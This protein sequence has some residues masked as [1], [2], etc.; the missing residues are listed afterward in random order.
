MTLQRLHWTGIRL[1]VSYTACRTS[2]SSRSIFDFPTRSD[3]KVVAFLTLGEFA[4][5]VGNLVVD[6]AWQ[7]C[8]VEPDIG[9]E[10]RPFCC[11]HFARDETI[12]KA[13]FSMTNDHRTVT[14]LCNKL[15]SL[16]CSIPQRKETKFCWPSS[17]SNSLLQCRVHQVQ[18]KLD[19]PRPV[20]SL[21]ACGVSLSLV[22]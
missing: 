10:P 8:A 5:L 11:L 2:Q 18:G 19:D 9:I 6:R 7:R 16:T 1:L 15:I 14:L 20:L 21:Y 17:K 13:L 4:T 3:V 12:G 22:L